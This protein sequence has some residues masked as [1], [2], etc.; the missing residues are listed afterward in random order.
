MI[1]GV[2]MGMI[3]LPAIVSV[4][5][6][7]TS[8]RAF[9]TGIAVC[10]SGVGTFLFAPFCQYLLGVTSWQNTLLILAFMILSC[11]GFGGLMRPLNVHAKTVLGEGELDD[12]QQMMENSE[13]RKPL[14]QRIAEEKRRRLLAHSNSQFLL[15]M[16]HG[17]LD[18]NDLTFTELKNRL[19]SMNMEPGVHSTLYLD[20]L[21]QPPTPTPQTPTPSA[22]NQNTDN[23]KDTVTGQQQQQQTCPS[24]TQS[25]SQLCI[26][27]KHQLS[28]IIESKKIF[29]VNSSEDNTSSDENI[30]IKENNDSEQ[31]EQDNN[32]NDNDNEHEQKKMADAAGAVA[33][34]YSND[35]EDEDIKS[36]INTPTSATPESPPILPQSPLSEIGNGRS[37]SALVTNNFIIQPRSR[38]STVRTVSESGQ[39]VDSSNYLPSSSLLP[40]MNSM[41]TS[42]QLPIQVIL[43]STPAGATL[44]SEESKDKRN[45]TIQAIPVRPLSKKD[46]FYSGSTLHVPSSL[47]HLAESGANIGQS[48]VSIPAR[49]IIAKVQKQIQQQETG[50]ADDDDDDGGGGGLKRSSYQKRNVCD[51]ILRVLCSFKDNCCQNNQHQQLSNGNNNIDDQN[52]SGDCCSEMNSSIKQQRQFQQQQQQQPND[53][54]RGYWNHFL[55]KLPPSM[56]SI[57]SEMLDFSLIRDSNAFIILAI[58][59]IFGMMGF[60]V[61]FVYITQFATSSVMGMYV[62]SRF[63]QSIN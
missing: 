59:N 43:S 51:K 35:Y 49:D 39:V 62:V 54:K 19:N 57:L 55:S 56:R 4:G 52:E 42:G 8:K 16:Q 27:Q 9:A 20:Q 1:G 45:I 5:Y 3:F 53:E 12:Q 10:G 40:Q 11:A 28:P 26:D 15:M 61:P 36:E 46:I 32:N 33:S 23:N 22:A 24:T 58:S 17:S 50:G 13:M 38:R 21:F 30:T 29:S 2:G 34:D 6:Y 60:Y 31:Q 7:F 25:Q 44:S 37:S 18:L 14:L 63:L 47:Q 48:I 41:G